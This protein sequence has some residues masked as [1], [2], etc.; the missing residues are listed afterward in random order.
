MTAI[1]TPIPPETGGCGPVDP[2]AFEEIVA[3]PSGQRLRIRPIRPEDE[4]LLRD[5]G[6]RTTAEDLRLRFFSAMKEVPHELAARLT[7]IDY[8]R[9][10]A[11]VAQRTDT[12]EVLGVA[13][14]AAEPESREAEFAVLV[15]SDWKGH[16]VGSVLMQ[17][18]VEIAR[19][20]G[21]GVLSGLVLRANTKMLE[22]CRSLGFTI[23]SIP[24]DL[25]TVH[26]LLVLDPPDAARTA[27]AD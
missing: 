23:T 15:R 2:R 1:D 26:A 10:M 27:R 20:R 16:G 5:M 24:D 9:E 13:R 18:L 11:L 17:Q 4:A 19:R 21:V 6:A 8:G 14:Y 25:A 12:D 22:F 7:H 3:L